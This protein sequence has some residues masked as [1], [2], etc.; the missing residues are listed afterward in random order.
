MTGDPGTE[1][2]ISTGVGVGGAE[3]NGVWPASSPVNY[4][5]EIRAAIRGRE[6]A[7]EVNVDVGER[8]VRNW[9]G[10]RRWGVV[11]V[12]LGTL[13]GKA[14]TAPGCDVI[15]LVRPDIP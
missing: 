1:E 7:N 4:G 5:E 11:A 13:T 8:A 6:R 12:N 3:R 10:L 2:G 14:G 15:S 9:N